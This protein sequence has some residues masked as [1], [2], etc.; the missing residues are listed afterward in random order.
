MAEDTAGTNGLELL[1]QECRKRFR[2]PENTD[3]Y[4][5][6]DYREAEKRYVKYCLFGEDSRR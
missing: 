4:S 3:H 5:E 6:Q 1:V 2:I